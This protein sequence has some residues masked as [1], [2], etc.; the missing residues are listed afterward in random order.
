MA[1]TTWTYDAPSGVYKNHDLSSQL[2]MAAIAETKFMQFVS[3]EAGYGRKKGESVTITRLSN[4]AN[5][6]DGKLVEGNKIPED[7]ITLS[8]V[9]IT[10]AE[11]GRA[12]PY[13]NLMEELSTFNV[14]NMIQSKLKDQMK[15]TLDSAA[16]KV[17]KG[18][19]NKIKAAPTGVASIT[20]DT[21][22][23]QS[24]TATSNLNVYHVEQIR[25]YMYG[26][27][28]VPAYSGDDYICIL[29]TK[30]KRGLINDPAWEKWHTY[31]DP[32]AKY[33]GEIGRLENVRFIETNNF[34]ALSNG[35]GSG[36][37]LGEAVFFGADAVAMAVAQDPE[38][39][40]G[41]PQDFG[42]QMSVAWYGIL[43]FGVVWNTAN[44][45]EARIVS[46][47]SA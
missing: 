25:D 26:T 28:K 1:E 40:A 12:V 39:R 41:I 4:I 27:L 10:V 34:D 43:N 20:F 37:V 29:T 38:L 11:W 9:A 42:R 45:G 46:V 2:R 8:T 31:T 23:T 14:E 16:A 35:V 30:A 21:D 7:E 18:T 15:L 13:T 44:A 47:G 32:A 3:T 33:N 19:D 5:P 17:F 6:T 36:S 24:T 22:G